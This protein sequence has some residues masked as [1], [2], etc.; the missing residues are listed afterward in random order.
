MT[1]HTVKEIAPQLG[2]STSTVYRWLAS[3][4]ITLHGYT[5]R[6]QGR[7]WII[8]A[9]T[10]PRPAQDL[11]S[12]IRAAYAEVTASRETWDGWIGLAELRPRLAGVPRDVLDAALDRMIER[13]DVRL[14]A[15]LNQKALTDQDWDA[16]VDIA[17]EPRHLI[18]IGD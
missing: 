16:A 1:T 13:P 14:Q 8:T 12:R 18:R 7:R 5:G 17:G 15:E 10:A 6:K 3:G 11:E 9:A 4:E 2:V